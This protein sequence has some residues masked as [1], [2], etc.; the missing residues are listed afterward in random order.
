MTTQ[1]ECLNNEF[2][3]GHYP[4]WRHPVPG[5]WVYKSN[6]SITFVP[7]PG[8]EGNMLTTLFPFHE[9]PV[10][11]TDPFD[12]TGLDTKDLRDWADAQEEVSVTRSTI[13]KLFRDIDPAAA[14]LAGV[15]CR[16]FLYT[17][18][19]AFAHEMRWGDPRFD[20]SAFMTECGFEE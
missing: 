20:F 11:S 3:E 17:L 4:L 1:W 7:D 10:K 15:S 6:G 13:A 2:G 9:G 8:I 14:D 18:A 16:S 19:E 5:G 12:I